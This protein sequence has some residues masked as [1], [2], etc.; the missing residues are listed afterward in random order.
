[1]R[2]G[3]SISR[4]GAYGCLDAGYKLASSRRSCRTLGR[5]PAALSTDDELGSRLV[6]TGQYRPITERFADIQLFDSD[7]HRGDETVELLLSSIWL[8]AVI[9]L[10]V[11]ALQQRGLLQSL[12]CTELP[13]ADRAAKVAVIVPARDE[14]AN[15]KRCLCSLAAQTYPVA[16]LRIIVIDDHSRDL[17]FAI[18]SALAQ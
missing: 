7:K 10:I 1:M 11:R 12:K 17:T 9:W 2:T 6:F 3:A 14:A 18:A 16:R 8:A 13:S 4:C 15:I 5:G